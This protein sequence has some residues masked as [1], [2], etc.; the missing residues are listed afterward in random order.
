MADILCGIVERIAKVTGAA[1][2][3]VRIGVVQF[4]GLVSGRRKTGIG[5]D[6]ELKNLKYHKIIILSDADQD[7]AHIRALLLTFFYRYTKELITG[8]HV[9]MGMPPLYK[10]QKGNNVTYAYDDEELARITKGMKGYT[11]QRYKGLGEMNPEQLWE[12][13]LDPEARSL[14][15]VKIN[16]MEEA[17]ETFATLM[18]DVVE[19][20]K[21]FIQDNALN[22]V[23][24]DI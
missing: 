6:F 5:E 7:G 23:N 1:F 2:F 17:D 4:A 24:L 9:Y 10:V 8:G 22:V 18:G 19:P 12:T 21:E 14:L 20:R 13:T 3:H 15:Q 16:Q 11:L